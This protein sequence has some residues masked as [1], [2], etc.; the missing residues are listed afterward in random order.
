MF[1]GLWKKSKDEPQHT[2][3]VI[4]DDPANA[5]AIAQL[6]QSAGYIVEVAYEN[7]EIKARLD[8]EQLPHAFIVYFMAPEIDGKRFVENARI[9]YG[10][11]KVPPI[12]M[13][14]PTVEDEITANQMQVEDCLP[15]P[16]D[17]QNLLNHLSG[18]VGSRSV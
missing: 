7:G 14:M 4:G 15:K 9:R 3:V 12:L 6:L 11:S 16:F 2:V 8:E 13:L 17:H 1:E 18:L 5:N 10:R